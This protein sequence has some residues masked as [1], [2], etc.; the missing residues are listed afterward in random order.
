MNRE[1]K[2]LLRGLKKNSELS[3]PAGNKIALYA[4]PDLR[5]NRFGAPPGACPPPTLD[6]VVGP[7]AL[8]V[9]LFCFFFSNASKNLDRSSSKGFF[10]GMG[11]EYYLAQF[12]VFTWDSKEEDH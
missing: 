7:P 4:D 11:G 9:V 10:L 12:L 8:P 5:W 2:R 3:F 1:R 6:P